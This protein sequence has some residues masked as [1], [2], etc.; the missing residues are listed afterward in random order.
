MQRRKQYVSTEH[1]GDEHQLRIDPGEVD[2]DTP[3]IAR[4]YDYFLGGAAHFAVDRQAA[5][6]LLAVF[7][8]NTDWARINRA[9]LGR[10][11]RELS[12]RGIDQ[13]LDLGSG[14]PTKGN[15]HEIAQQHDPHARVAYVDIEPVAVSHASHLLRENSHVTV[16]QADIR[17]PEAVLSAPGV[18]GLLDFTRPVAVLAVAVLDIIAVDDPAE[19]VAAYQRACTPGSAFVLSHG[20]QLQA[21]DVEWAGAKEVFRETTTPHPQV[22]TCGEIAELCA[23]YTL[24]EPGLVPSAQWRPERP[25]SEEEAAR[26]NGYAAVGVL[27]DVRR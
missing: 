24:I 20:A 19:L 27:E 16:T 22:R 5:E 18:A 7:P 12:R 8:G 13:F 2:L 21:S 15:V 9:F 25:V 11:V 6:E 1:S 23:G 17:E 3:N 4:M 10:A 26:S 14:I